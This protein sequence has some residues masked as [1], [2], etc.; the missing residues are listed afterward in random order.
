MDLFPKTIFYSK[1]VN[2]KTNLSIR[3]KER[4]KKIGKIFREKSF[5]KTSKLYIIFITIPSSQSF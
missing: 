2:K 3:L 5:F 4:R 1:R